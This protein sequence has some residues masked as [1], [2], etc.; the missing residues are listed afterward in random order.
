MRAFDLQVGR[1]LT[2][3]LILIPLKIPNHQPW[4]A[5]CTLSAGCLVRAGDQANTQRAILS[6]A[7]WAVV[8]ADE[9][10]NRERRGEM[11]WL[12]VIEYVSV[13]W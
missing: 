11:L 5:A 12:M 7:N 13:P 6:R 1:A 8:E 3:T 4:V 9:G 2:E 10:L